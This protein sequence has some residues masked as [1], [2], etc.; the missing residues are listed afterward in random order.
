MFFFTYTFTFT[1]PTNTFTIRTTVLNYIK[2]ADLEALKIL[3]GYDVKS[4]TITLVPTKPFTIY[5]FQNPSNIS[6]GE[7]NSCLVINNTNLG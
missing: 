4:I 1:N 5:D 7:N 6:N 3:K 2:L